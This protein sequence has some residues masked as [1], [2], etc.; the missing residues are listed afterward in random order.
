MRDSIGYSDI[1]DSMNLHLGQVFE[2][3]FEMTDYSGQILVIIP[4]TQKHNSIKFNQVMDMLS[5]RRTWYYKK[6]H[7]G[8]TVFEDV[9]E[10]LDIPLEVKYRQW[11]VYVLK[12]PSEAPLEKFLSTSDEDLQK[13]YEL[14]RKLHRCYETVDKSLRGRKVLPYLRKEKTVQDQKKDIKFS[15]R[16]DSFR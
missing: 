8:E 3:D 13:A 6:P 4:S 12:P 2:S 9:L 5:H 1:Y 15:E 14:H 11:T 7:A 16:A 10:N